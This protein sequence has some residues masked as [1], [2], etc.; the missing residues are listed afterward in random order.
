MFNFA[1]GPAQLPKEVLARAREEMLDWH[2][3]GMSVMEL[4]F[5]SDEYKEISACAM[6]DLRSLLDLHEGYRILFLQGGAYAHFALVAMNLMGRHRAADYVHTGH[7]SHRAI[8]EAR[9]IGEI[10][11]AASAEASNF[12]RIP[13]YADWNLDPRAAYC[14]ITS[15]E[16]ADG[17][18][19]HW[20]PDTGDVPLVADVTS[21]LLTRK[22]DISRFGLVYASAQKNLGTAGLTIVI[23]R[24]DLLE[25]AM[26]TLP[27]VFNYG[28]Q[29]RNDSRVNTT[30]IF[31]IYIAGLIFS[32]LLKQGGLEVIEQQNRHKSRSLYAVIDDDGLFHCDVLPRDRS[33]VNVCFDVGGS[34]TPD[35]IDEARNNGFLNLEGHGAHGGIRASLYNAMPLEAVEALIGFMRDYSARHDGGG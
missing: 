32:W 20:L 6:R 15:N 12:D 18:Q 22:L 30:P 29:A 27:I 1:A 34:L 9:R 17:L 25:Q 21:D 26:D 4:P 3:C 16:T 14:H 7:W 28:Q 2:G 33:M 10:R 23:I 24:E 31:S 13:P 5:S 8:T 19:F 35:F 11:I